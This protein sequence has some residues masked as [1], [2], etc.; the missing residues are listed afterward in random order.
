[1]ILRKCANEDARKRV[2]MACNGGEGAQGETDKVEVLEEM[3][4]TRAKVAGLVGRSS[5]G[6]VELENKMAQK[7]GQ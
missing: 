1:M 4:R 2:W 7:P 5:W 3:L 6:E